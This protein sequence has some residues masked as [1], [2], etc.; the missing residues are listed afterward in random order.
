ASDEVKRVRVGV[1]ARRK[2]RDAHEPLGRLPVGSQAAGKDDPDT[3][4]TMSTLSWNSDDDL[5]GGAG[6]VPQ[7][8]KA[9]KKRTAKRWTEEQDNQLRAGVAKYK[10]Q[11]WKMIAGMVDGRDHVQ[12]LQRWKKVLQPGLVKGMWSKEEDALLF[13]LVSHKLPKNWADVAAKIP[14]R[15]AKQCRERWSLNLDPSINRDAWTKEE[16]EL[17]VSLHAKMGNRWAE[18]KRFMPGRTENGVKT[19]YKSIERA[20]EKDKEVRWTPELEAQLERV[21]RRFEGRMDEISKHLPRVLRGI[22]SQAMRD[23]CE[24]LCKFEN[25]ARLSR[26]SST[27]STSVMSVVSETSGVS[28]T[29]V[30]S[31]TA[32]VCAL[33]R[34][35]R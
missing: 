12:C 16:D 20:R 17:L 15:T 22:S 25:R 11:N 5:V 3:P 28:A 32:A 18:I 35:A 34:K 33:Q 29:P 19:R 9:R 30:S 14:G 6:K 13:E 2:G 10:A 26:R 21:V 7:A 24:L 4:R 23:H 31:P 8:G 1:A 27:M